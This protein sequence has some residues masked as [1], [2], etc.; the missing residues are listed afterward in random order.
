[1]ERISRKACTEVGSIAATC[2]APRT[3]AE[4][5]AHGILHTTSQ[6][7]ALG[8]EVRRAR[9]AHEDPVAATL[10]A[11]HGKK[12]F[13]GKIA[14][15]QRRATEGFLRGTAKIDGIDEDRGARFELAFQNEYAIGWRDGRVIV[16]TPDLICVLDSVSGEAIG[17][18]S[19]RY[20]QRVS[21]IALPAPAILRTPKG[22]AHVGPRAFGHDT[23][24][25]SVFEPPVSE[26]VEQR[27]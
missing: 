4:V 5:K 1:M 27:P 25:V 2:K 12:L 11:A 22:I 26:A 3:G 15:V 18:E 16:T 6:A 21:V 24:Y 8:R 19:L 7:I 10:A 20:G 9:H 17:T 23:D 13:R 14:D